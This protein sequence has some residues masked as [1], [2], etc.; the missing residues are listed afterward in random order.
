MVKTYIKIA[1]YAG[2]LVWSVV[3]LIVWIPVLFYATSNY[4]IAVFAASL[5]GQ[6]THKD[7]EFV[8]RNKIEMYP[9][10]FKNFELVLTKATYNENN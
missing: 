4:C 7:E 10:G 9:R 1:T 6:P 5:K 2:I 3:G 8:L